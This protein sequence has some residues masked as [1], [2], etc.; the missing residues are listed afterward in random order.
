MEAFLDRCRV[1]AQRDG[2]DYALMN[3]DVPPEIAL[4]QYLLRRS[5]AQP[6]RGAPRGVRT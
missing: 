5:H 1:H 3:T 6:V 4:R 2:V